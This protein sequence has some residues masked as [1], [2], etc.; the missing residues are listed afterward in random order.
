MTPD[1]YLE[2]F[3]FPVDWVKVM[4]KQLLLLH[5]AVAAYFSGNQ[6]GL[7]ATLKQFSITLKAPNTGQPS[8]I[9]G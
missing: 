9:E 4:H 2:V 8:F 1:G 7:D 3:M 5:N 6:A